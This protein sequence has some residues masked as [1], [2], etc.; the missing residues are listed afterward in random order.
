VW[1][2]ARVK[3]LKSEKVWARASV[4]ARDWTVVQE[5]APGLVQVAAAR[6]EREQG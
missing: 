1:V 4:R 2:R 3:A 6:R 5:Q